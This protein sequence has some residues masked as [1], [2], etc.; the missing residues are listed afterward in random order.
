MIKHHEYE[1]KYE[2]MRNLINLHNDVINVIVNYLMQQD[3]RFGL[4]IESTIQTSR[5]PIITNHQSPI[6]NNY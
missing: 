2:E 5:E 1:R 6:T 4:L 3:N